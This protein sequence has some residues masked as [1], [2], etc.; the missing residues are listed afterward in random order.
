MRKRISTGY[1]KE[2]T[3]KA[4]YTRQPENRGQDK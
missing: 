1:R 2:A 4:G 3:R